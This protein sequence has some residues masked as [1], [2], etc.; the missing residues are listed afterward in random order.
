MV[1]VRDARDE[2]AAMYGPGAVAESL[3]IYPVTLSNLIRAGSA[4]ESQQLRMYEV[5]E[6]K[7]HG[8][9]WVFSRERGLSSG[10]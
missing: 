9:E 6:E 1:R 10:E 8:V 3:V 2:Q 4:N 7:Y 5:R